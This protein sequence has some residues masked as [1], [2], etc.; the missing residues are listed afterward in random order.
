MSYPLFSYKIGKF[1]D[2][3]GVS[4]QALQRWDREGILKAHRTPT[5]RRYYTYQQYL[6]S[7]YK[8]ILHKT[9]KYGLPTY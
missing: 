5:N 4:Y 9:T 6:A 1:A 2:M 7:V 3:I 8:G